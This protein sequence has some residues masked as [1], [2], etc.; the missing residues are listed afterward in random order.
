MIY[1]IWYIESQVLG[2]S[3]V[4]FNDTQKEYKFCEFK[5]VK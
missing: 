5:I 3:A 2:T 4:Y 1:K